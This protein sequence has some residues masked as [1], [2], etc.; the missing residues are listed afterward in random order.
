MNSNSKKKS[1]NSSKKEK[2]EG[3]VTGRLS[4]K[5]DL[6]NQLPKERKLIADAAEAV[7]KIPAD[8][9]EDFARLKPVSGRISSSKPNIANL[10]RPDPATEKGKCHFCKKDCKDDSYCYGC[11]TFICDSCD[12][13]PAGAFGNHSPSIHKESD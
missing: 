5:S 9:L 3:V 10:P 6:R 13:S 12:K 4:A 2:T 1:K 11:K 8:E 7:E